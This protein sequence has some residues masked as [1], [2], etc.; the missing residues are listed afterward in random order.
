[1]TKFVLLTLA[2]LMGIGFITVDD[3]APPRSTPKGIS[4]A[5]IQGPTP[6]RSAPREAKDNSR[7]RAVVLSNLDVEVIRWVRGGFETVMVVDFKITNNNEFDVKDVSIKCDHFAASGTHIDSG[8]R[9]IYEVFP[10]GK[11]RTIKGFNMGRIHS[12]AESSGCS[13]VGFLSVG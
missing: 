4:L 13:A 3:D 1:M 9:A 12:Q 11:S 5:E 10:G 7:N 6:T 8:T 2:I